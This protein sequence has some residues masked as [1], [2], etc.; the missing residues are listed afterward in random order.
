MHSKYNRGGNFWWWWFTTW[1][2][3]RGF[4]TSTATSDEAL[5]QLHNRSGRDCRC[6]LSPSGAQHAD[7]CWY[8]LSERQR[9]EAK[10]KQQVLKVNTS[11][12]A[13]L[14]PLISCF[15]YSSRSSSSENIPMSQRP[16]TPVGSSRP[17]SPIAQLKE[18]PD[19]PPCYTMSSHG[20][21]PSAQNTLQRKQHQGRPPP[22][23]RTSSNPPAGTV[24]KRVQIQ[25][26]SV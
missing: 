17:Q 9:T 26:I 22:P 3:W 8:L 20:G 18:K 6:W 21:P 23:M 4:W 19:L 10:A 7:I 14:D 11:K 2:Q 15:L 24:K 25:E 13:S 16:A 1:R 5:L 12:S